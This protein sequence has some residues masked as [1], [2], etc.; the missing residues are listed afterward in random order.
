MLDFLSMV[1]DMF[2]PFFSFVFPFLFL[3]V[4][5]SSIMS[6][7]LF[8]NDSREIIEDYFNRECIK[9]MKRQ[10]RAARRRLI[11]YKRECKHKA[12]YDFYS[13]N[14]NAMREKRNNKE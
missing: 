5:I 14:D 9:H 6:G 7:F 3:I 4:V 10:R 1:F 2:S 12:N 13:S 11:K 8:E